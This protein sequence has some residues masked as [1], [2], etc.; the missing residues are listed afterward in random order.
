[1]ERCD[2]RLGRWL[3]DSWRDVRYAFRLLAASPGFTVLAILSLSLGIGANTA[4]FQLIDAIRFRHLPVPRAQELAD[5]RIAGGNAGWGV[6]EDEN[7]QLTYPL[8]EQ[9]QRRQQAFSGLFAWG[10]TPFLIETGPGA[11]VVRGL[12][13]SGD[14]FPVLGVAS[15]I[16]RLI[17][18]TDDQRGC[19]PVVVLNDAF[20]QTHFGGDRSAVGR[21]LTIQDRQVPVIGV[22]S[23]EFF[24]VD[25][26]RRFDIALPICAAA[27]WGSPLDRR[28]W[29]WL[30]VSGRLNR[31]WTVARAAEHM[32]AISPGVFEATLTG[33]RDARSLEKYRRFRLTI[34]PAANGV[35]HLRT[36]YGGALWLLLAMTGLV[37]LMGCFNV[38]NLLLA[39]SSAREQELA[40]RV[41][42]GASRGRVIAQLLIESLVLA[43]CGA[44]PGAALAQALSRGILALLTTEN[45]PLHLDLRPDW[46][47][48]VFTATAG[49][50]TCVVFGLVPAL[51][52]PRSAPAAAMKTG[53]G[54]TAG[55]GWTA[56]RRGLVVA[57]LALS[58]VLMVGAALFVGSFRNLIT[59]DTGLRREGVIFG[60][61][62]D[63]NDRP[64][65]GRV[66]AAQS[67]LLDR[68]RAVP[69]VLSAATTTK[70]PLDA[71]SWTM[72]FLLPGSEDLTRHSSKFTYVAPL[73]FFTVGMQILAGRDF[74]GSDT[75]ASRR[76]AIV[77]QMFVRRYFTTRNAVGAT[78][79]TVAEPGYP[80]TMYEVV[81]IVSDT[82]YSGLREPVQPVAFVPL[83]QHPSVPS[84]PNIVIRSNGSPAV[85]IAAVKRAV[86]ELRPTLS[87]SFTLFETQVREDLL[88]E[89]LLA[90][91]AGAFGVLAAL[92]TAVGVYGLI[93]YV[94]SRRQH[95]IAIRLALGAGR[96]RVVR[97]VLG[98]M[99][100]LLIVGL[101]CG[102]TLAVLAARAAQALL[103]G[104]SPHDP[105]T[106]LVAIAVLTGLAAVACTIPALRASR[107]NATAALRSE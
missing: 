105:M 104:L 89:R 39:R 21:S 58:F 46:L 41:A 107:V 79:R 23:R 64:V 48:L 84:W 96:T 66:L 20:W 63:F 47:V 76:I 97:L 38:M 4:V 92:L 12:W 68:I 16:G 99:G 65:P 82:K 35:S 31:G 19:A 28:D 42:I 37:L 33:G 67:E 45:N 26:G 34:L 15:E 106:F 87:S 18:P 24:G 56:I 100:G 1:M 93:S 94:V 43:A 27:L 70:F 10:T 11:R 90:W 102:V 62:A 22:T 83:A 51:R 6:S 103:F 40:V 55:R 25:V 5:V 88:P 52:A 60:R 81:G 44:L 71:S 72:G 61:V 53:R 75:A 78:L 85:V 59:L 2:T 57:Q 9:I 98:E 30:S 8:W 69:Q 91:L 32:R 101:V 13:V 49:I 3:D 95:E 80:E 54:L 17:G 77:N 7:S 73:Y 86:G 29:F 50:A 74:N 36:T 14:A